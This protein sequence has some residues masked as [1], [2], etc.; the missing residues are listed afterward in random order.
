MFR[1][2]RYFLPKMSPLLSQQRLYQA[3]VF[4][5]TPSLTA[6]IKKKHGVF[7]LQ[8]LTTNQLGP[9]LLGKLTLREEFFGSAW[10]TVL[11][12][13]NP[14][15]QIIHG[16]G[17][18]I[19]IDP[20]RRSPI[21]ADQIV[22]PEKLYGIPQNVWDSFTQLLENQ[23]VVHALN[24][25]QHRHLWLGYRYAMSAS[26][27]SLR[28]TRAQLL[29]QHHFLLPIAVGN[30]E[31]MPHLDFADVEATWFD[32]KHRNEWNFAAI[33]AIKT[34]LDQGVFDSNKMAQFH[35]GITKVLLNKLRH[36]ANFL[37]FSL[38][39]TLISNYS[40]FAFES[41]DT[42]KQHSAINWIA[43]SQT[44][45][46]RFAQSLQ[47]A[48]VSSRISTQSGLLFFN[49]RSQWQSFTRPSS[50]QITF[51]RDYFDAL[52]HDLLKREILVQASALSTLIEDDML[53]SI[54]EKFEAQIIN[55]A[56]ISQCM[57]FQNRWQ[58]NMHLIHA[59]KPMRN[60]TLSWSPLIN[61]IEFNSIQIRA[62]KSHAELIQTGIEMKNCLQSGNFTHLC[63][64]NE[65]NLLLLIDKQKSKSIIH[66]THDSNYFLKIQQ[67][68]GFGNIDANFLHLQTGVQLVRAINSGEIKL[69][70]KRKT[71]YLHASKH[72]LN[73]FDYEISDLQTQENVYQKYK[74][75]GLLPKNLIFANHREMLVKT[76]LDANITKI[77]SF[78]AEVPSFRA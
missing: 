16:K 59:A 37:D 38:L 48:K 63:L 30:L 6:R 36:C 69:F 34:D 27:P 62:L 70:Q 45:P 75:K 13:D 41:V 60:H 11:S 43:S 47:L 26:T 1:T 61:N 3:A 4:A 31:E 25:R 65:G 5:N 55:Q 39:T 40:K 51:C 23:D 73:E 67:H 53:Q 17:D 72:P 54:K 24:L 12:I 19:A 52:F 2:P 20:P 66:L 33:T 57:Y 7:H 10:H 42:N 71:E 29:G 50:E 44:D 32:L 9:Q 56:T 18:T 46:L 49:S 78:V 64:E 76:G 14:N 58:H 77:L 74:E 15:Q 35:S 22:Y 8:A 68:K 28:I 21:P